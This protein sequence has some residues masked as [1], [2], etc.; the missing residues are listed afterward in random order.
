MAL[1]MTTTEMFLLA[2]LLIY[3][4]PFL[5]WQLLRVDA[6]APLA[7][8]QIMCG[9]ALGPGILG[10]LYPGFHAMVFSP[11]VLAPLN[12]IAWWGV[13]VFVFLAGVEID[14]ATA[15]DKR[16]ET[17]VT[18]GL[19]LSVPLLAGCAAAYGLLWYSR[20]WI[21]PAGNDV[22][23]I[24]GLGMA[25]AVTALPILVLLLEKLEI[26]RS[27]FG[28]RVLRY[29]SLDD[30]MIWSVLALILLDYERL[31][32]QILFLCLFAGAALLIRKI[33]QHQTEKDRWFTSL[34][35][36]ATASFCADWA[37]L[38]FMVGA[39]LAGL[40]VDGR[41]LSLQHVDAYRGV[42]LT[43]LMPVFFLSTGLRTSWNLGGYTVIAA[44]FV[45]LVAS[46]AGKLAGV[47]F[48]GHILGWPKGEALVIGWLL[49]TKALIMI[50]FANILLDKGIISSDSFTALLLMAVMSTVLTMPMVRKSVVHI[51]AKTK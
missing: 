9:I 43:V 51:A 44:A 23:A 40:I 17:L 39:F 25:C 48:A 14:L 29:A 41:S 15:W 12:G 2:L 1:A 38:H 28:Q 46:I 6:V 10:I 3:A 21:G 47:A 31:G 50:V 36:L 45:L 26:L 16:R 49:Q 24:L 7:V 11:A 20:I 30:V 33:L 5:L 32:R 8:V 4:V 27:D 19:A 34:I 22:Q 18:S 37:G 42:V 13:M 35:W